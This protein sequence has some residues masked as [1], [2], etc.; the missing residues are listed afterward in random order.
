M[1]GLAGDP[2]RRRVAPLKAAAQQRKLLGPAFPG[3]S[4]VAVGQIDAC[5]E[6]GVETL[7]EA[8]GQGLRP[9]VLDM[10]Q[11]TAGVGRQALHVAGR[12]VGAHA[13][14]AQ[15]LFVEG[16]AREAQQA[17]NLGSSQVKDK[18]TAFGLGQ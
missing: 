8:E 18:V 15:P 5:H 9:I 13:H 11:D 1:V 3:R 14:A 12:L 16:R 10:Q 4:T 7:H 6:V 17:H 2:R